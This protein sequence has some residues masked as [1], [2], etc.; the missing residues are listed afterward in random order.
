MEET[1]SKESVKFQSAIEEMEVQI[2]ETKDLLEATKR[3]ME[4]VHVADNE[5]IETLT[6]DNEKLK[7]NFEVKHVFFAYRKIV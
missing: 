3:E 7:V 6:T 5:K 4:Q 2:Q 1:K